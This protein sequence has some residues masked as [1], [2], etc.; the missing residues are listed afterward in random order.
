MTA[1]N[2]IKA[3]AAAHNSIR[4][5]MRTKRF[6]SGVKIQCSGARQAAQ[7]ISKGKRRPQR[8][9]TPAPISM[10]C[11]TREGRVV[12]IQCSGE[13]SELHVSGT[14]CRRICVGGA[15]RPFRRRGIFAGGGATLA[16]P[17]AGG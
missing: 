4:K 11:E 1:A 14:S 13:N 6:T 12:L 3:S 5:R 15:Q 16:R 10:E 7:P 9:R 8:Q 2:A 17:P